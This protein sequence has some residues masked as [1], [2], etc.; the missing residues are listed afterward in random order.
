MK[1]LFMI[2]SIL[3]LSACTNPEVIRPYV[4]GPTYYKM[5]QCYQYEYPR[6][7]KQWNSDLGVYDVYIRTGNDKVELC[8]YN[9]L[10]QP[11]Y[12]VYDGR[13]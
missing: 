1:K 11:M 3:L 7:I 13:N 12:G 10:Y 4:G 2:L 8:N 5:H 6:S 9:K